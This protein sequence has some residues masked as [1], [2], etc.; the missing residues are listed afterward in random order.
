MTTPPN[1]TSPQSM[2]LGALGSQGVGRVPASTGRVSKAD[3]AGADFAQLLGMARGG[4]IDSARE[5]AID[6]GVK[7]DLTPQQRAAL[8]A[9]ADRAEAAGLS[10]AL[11][12][13]GGQGL[14]LDVASRTVTGT[15][16]LSTPGVLGEIDG[17]VKAPAIDR[18]APALRPPLPPIGNMTLAQALTRDEPA[19]PRAAAAR[20][21]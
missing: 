1:T 15:A 14:M 3:I 12:M 13:I 2:L 17:V 21:R 8:G 4:Q 19:D 20:S 16:D 5:V 9:A 11:V 6:P 10:R 7:L 18:A